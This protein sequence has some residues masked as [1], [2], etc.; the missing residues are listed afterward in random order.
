MDKAPASRL[1]T[2]QLGSS[3]DFDANMTVF[4]PTDMP[5]PNRYQEQQYSAALEDLLYAVHQAMGGSVLT[6]FTNRRDM[7]QMYSRLRDR[8]ED[9][10]LPLLCQYRG[11]SRTRLRERFVANERLSLFALRSF[12]EGFDAPGKTLRCVIIP[13]LPFGRPNDPL[14]QERDLREQRAWMRYSLPQAVISLKQAAGRLIR[15]SQDSGYLV[16][17]DSRLI[18]KFYGKEFLAA[19]PSR[20][21][22]LLSRQEMAQQMR[23]ENS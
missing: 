10:G 6:L 14:Q 5:E 22:H 2:L 3:Y 12:W 15:S 18:S 17:A 4:V 21:I 1:L 7:E 9:E 11:L 23:D 20:N 16:L 8:L 19:L 13:K